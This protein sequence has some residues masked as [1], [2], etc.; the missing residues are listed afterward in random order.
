M[1]VRRAACLNF[2]SARAPVDRPAFLVTDQRNIRLQYLRGLA[3]VAVVLYHASQYL[4]DLRGDPR[5]L[6]VFSGFFGGYGVAVFFALSG[7]LMAE[8]LRR[9]ESGKFLTSRLARIYPPMLLVVGLFVVVFILIGRPRGINALSLTLIPSGPRDYFLGVEWTL[10]Y[11][12][13]YYVGLS[14]LGFIGL[15][16]FRTAAIVAWLTLLGLAYIWGEGRVEKPFPTLSEMPLNIVNLPFVLGYLTSGAH[17]RGWLPPLLSVPAAACALAVPFAQPDHFRLLVGLSASILV[18]AAIRAPVARQAGW[19]SQLGT[20]FGDASYALYLCHVPVILVLAWLIS[21]A[22][23]TP[24]VWLLWVSVA[25]GLSL[26]L[27]PLDLILHRRLKRLVDAAPPLRL[28]AFALT[29]IAAFIGIAI[30]TERETRA[31]T[32]LLAQAERILATPIVAAGLSVSAAVDAA[33]R[34]PN[35]RWV[36][37]G[38]GIDL[39]RPELG[40]HFAVRQDGKI[41]VITGMRRMRAATAQALG[42]TDLES[43]RFGFMVFLPA[44][45]SCSKGPLEGVLVLGDG[46]AVPLPPGALRN[47][48]P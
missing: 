25:V 47:V 43:L 18:A 44:D 21:P 39:E 36:L 12:M 24:V 31:D 48:C 6:S 28:K 37:R 41:V 8:L 17:Q 34:L 4:A 2:R 38:Y 7:Y 3:A 9:D 26:C 14:L 42:R 20:R 30:Y 40:A 15:A 27:G 19:L 23:P 16:R 32:A 45:V 5:F 10:L 29:F 46:R 1:S 22:V 35:G 33:E 13:T 11:E